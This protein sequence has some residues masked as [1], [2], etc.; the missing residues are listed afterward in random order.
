MVL[1]MYNAAVSYPRTSTNY[2]SININ[3]WR[4]TLVPNSNSVNYRF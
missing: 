3:H 4:C 2:S 1:C